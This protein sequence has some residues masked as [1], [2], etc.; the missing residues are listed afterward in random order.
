MRVVIEK[1]E[2]IKGRM[3]EEHK[4]QKTQHED[5]EHKEG[6]VPLGRR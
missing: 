2:M 6:S 3:D 4:P 5:E 1:L